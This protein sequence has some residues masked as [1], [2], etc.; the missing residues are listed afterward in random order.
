MPRCRPSIEPK[1]SRAWLRNI[2]ASPRSRN[3]RWKTWSHGYRHSNETAPFPARGLGPRGPAGCCP[4]FPAAAG[5]LVAP[6]QGHGRREGREKGRRLRAAADLREMQVR[7]AHEP[8]HVTPV[9]GRL[10]LI[11]LVI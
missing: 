2:A 6:R 1:G 10:T 11:M 7:A 8:R 5:H 4:A 9:R 3:N